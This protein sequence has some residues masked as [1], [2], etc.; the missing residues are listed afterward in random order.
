MATRRETVRRIASAIGSI[1]DPR[2]ADAVAREVVCRALAVDFSHLVADYDTECSI[3]N[4]D[5]LIEELCA[6]RPVQYVTGVAEF[7]EMDFVVREGVLIPRPET[8]ELV[9]LVAGCVSDGARILDVGTGSGAIAVSLAR[10]VRDARVTAVDISDVALEVAREN[11]RKN[12]V[13]V[14]FVKMDALGDMSSLGEFDAI[15]SNPPYVPQSDRE[16]MHC[17]VREYEPPTALFVP[18]NDP[19]LFYRSIAENARCMLVDGGVLGFEIYELYGEQMCAMLRDRDFR[20]VEIVKDANL[21][22]RMVWCRK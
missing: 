2:E 18:D 6:G 8:E 22:D 10:R 17:N 15:V 1:Y 12:H 13:Q 14:E 11:A 16:S 3:A 7:C 9:A 21:K 4:L 5:A 19:L 20:D